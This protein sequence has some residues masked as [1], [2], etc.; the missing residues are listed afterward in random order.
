MR[1]DCYRVGTSDAGPTVALIMQA[2]VP[3]R[4]NAAAR[5]V[6]LLG[7]EGLS[8]VAADPVQQLAAS[9]EPLPI[10]RA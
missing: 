7:A 1:A 3:G 9:N 2:S 8:V 5:L 4:R 10:A 6:D